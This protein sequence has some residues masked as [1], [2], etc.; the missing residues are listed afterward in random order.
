MSALENYYSGDEHWER[1]EALFFLH[2]DVPEVREISKKLAGN[3]GLACVIYGTIG[4]RGAEWLDRKIPVLDDIRPLDCVND[5]VLI[6][7][8]REALMRFP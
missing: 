8:L 7:R 3:V 4:H 5:P 2:K 1:F 6:K